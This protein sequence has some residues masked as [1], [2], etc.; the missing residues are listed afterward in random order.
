MQKWG[1]RT[2]NAHLFERLYLSFI[3]KVKLTPCHC[4]ASCFYHA[5]ILHLAGYYECMR[6]LVQEKIPSS[7]EHSVTAPT[8]LAATILDLIRKPLDAVTANPTNTVFR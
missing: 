3:I 7:I 5:Y 1:A 6:V 4:H 8:P 2:W